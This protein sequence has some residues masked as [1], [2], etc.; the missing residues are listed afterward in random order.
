MVQKDTGK[1]LD[2][3]EATWNPE[4]RAVHPPH[5]SWLLHVLWG[6]ELTG[7]LSLWLLSAEKQA[8]TPSLSR[9][10]TNLMSNTAPARTCPE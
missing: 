1:T 9:Q 8:P 6:L 5:S 7:D 4:C 2:L 3:P 10:H